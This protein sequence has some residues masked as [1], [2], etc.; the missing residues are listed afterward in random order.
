[1]HYA[2]PLSQKRGRVTAGKEMVS[3]GI[4]YARAVTHLCSYCVGDCGVTRLRIQQTLGVCSKHI[5]VCCDGRRLNAGN[6]RCN[7]TMLLE[8]RRDRISEA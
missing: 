6:Y 3:K 8:N 1:M 2:M 4:S 5:R 7:L